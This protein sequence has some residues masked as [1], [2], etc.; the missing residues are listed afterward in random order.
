LAAS[1]GEYDTGRSSQPQV[2]YVQQQVD[3]VPSQR[4][5]GR[6]VACEKPGD[7]FRLMKRCLQTALDEHLRAA[8]ALIKHVTS[9]D[10]AFSAT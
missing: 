6:Y 4:L 5:P 9:A 1:G 7:G 8:V 3:A 10:V 2:H